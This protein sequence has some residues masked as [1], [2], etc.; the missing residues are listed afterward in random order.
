[1]TRWFYTDPLAAAWMAKHFGMRFTCQG[2]GYDPLQG[3]PF[4]IEVLYHFLDTGY[5]SNLLPIRIHPDSLHLLQPQIGDILNWQTGKGEP[6]W[7]DHSR[8]IYP[9]QG[10]HDVFTAESAARML[11]KPELS[12]RIILR[13]G[14]AFMWP[15]REAV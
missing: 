8:Y 4:G 5:A 7:E 11:A 10:T 9:R 2:N 1:M 14:T 3:K 13:S 15:E 6:W 12:A